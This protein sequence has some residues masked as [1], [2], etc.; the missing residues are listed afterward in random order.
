[1]A[2]PSATGYPGI[3]YAA[4]PSATAFYQGGNGLTGQVSVQ[5]HAYWAEY[6]VWAGILSPLSLPS[7]QS[8]YFLSN[9]VSQMY[10]KNDMSG[11]IYDTGFVQTVWQF[12]AAGDG[13]YYIRSTMN[14][15]LLGYKASSKPRV[16]TSFVGD[17]PTANSLPAATRQTYQWKI[18]ALTDGFY[19]ISNRALPGVYLTELPGGVGIRNLDLIASPATIVPPA[20]EW[21]FKPVI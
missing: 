20:A 4:T 10:L 2:L 17:V 6:P 15:Q 11:L 14:G 5:G 21:T 19:R 1:M 13:Y 18:E 7:L 8:H 16:A 3:D 9:Q 12:D